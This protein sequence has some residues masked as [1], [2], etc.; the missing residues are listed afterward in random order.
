MNHFGLLA[1]ILTTALLGGCTSQNAT[2]ATPRASVETP[3]RLGSGD[4]LRVI[5]FGQDN[6]SNS[7]SVDGAGDISMPLIGRVRAQGLA[8]A[9]LEHT[10]E[11]RLRQGFLR[12]PSVS[13]EVEAYRPF[14]VLGEVTVAGQYPFIMGMTVQKAIAVA[15]GF[16]PRAV[17]SSVDITRVVDGRPATFPAPLSFPLRPGDAITVEERFF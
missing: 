11:A 8:T 15:G 13:V 7:F 9:E 3:Y 6:L 16:T 4:R 2:V 17:E 5:V 12:E 10:I 1:A 14:F